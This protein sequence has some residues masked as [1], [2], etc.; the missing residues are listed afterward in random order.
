LAVLLPLRVAAAEPSSAAG[1]ILPPVSA[2]DNRQP[3]GYDADGEVRIA[4]RVGAGV[5]RPHGDEGA[6]LQIDA[7][8]EL[9]K[10]LQVPAPLVRVRAG[11]RIAISVRNDLN[12]LVRVQGLCARDGGPCAPLEIAAGQTRE[13]RFA[14]GAAGTYH[15]WATTTG[16]PLSFRATSDSQL[17]GAFIVDPAEGAAENDRVLVITEWTSLTRE[18]LRDIAGR[19]DP[20]AAFLDLKPA[21][22]FTVNGLSW[23]H[24]ERLSYSL[25]E[26]V[27]WRVVNLSSQVHPMHLHGFYFEIDSVGDGL[28]YE[29]FAPGRRQRAVTHLVAPGAT[30]GLTWTPESAGH[31]LFHCHTMVHVSPL[32]HVDGSPRSGGEHDHQQPGAGMVGLVLGIVVNGPEERP[33]FSNP[34]PAVR[35][36]TLAMQSEA[37]RFEDE[38]A[39]GFL[40]DPDEPGKPAFVPVSV[41]GPLLVLRRGE[42]VEITLVNRLHEPTS[43]HWHGMELESYYDGVHGWSG[44]GRQVT[45][46]IEPGGTFVVRFTPPRAG[47]FIYHTHL[48]DNRQ[49]TSGLYGALLVVDAPEAFDEAVDHVFVLGRGG[50][51]FGAPLVV[52]GHPSPQSV[53]RAGTRH[54][55]RLIN[56]TPN[57]IVAVSLRTSA[58]IADWRPLAKDGAPLPGVPAAESASQVIGVGETYDFEYE[59]PH[60]RQ[61]LWLEVRSAAGRWLA[62]GHVIVK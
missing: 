55:I 61:T 52:N 58:A 18:Q 45:P 11:T 9:T 17:S 48:H 57:D 50:P 24:T 26:T 54:R 12:A 8:G 41:P 53:W 35:R 2:N 27:R 60:G 62:Q 16:M 6:A 51:A 22:L 25:G 1:G 49:L 4:L 59:A 30:A 38:P 34:A 19:P 21:V 3:A 46:L 37:A 56:I 39:M 5:W 47:T 42:P 29:P 15:Y 33:A 43:I 7:F 36:I 20:G 31:W 40:L 14:S 10:P 32:L 23:P 44:S 28:R 13:V